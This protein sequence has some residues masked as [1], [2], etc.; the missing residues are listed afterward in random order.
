MYMANPIILSTSPVLSRTNPVIPSK[1]RDYF[2]QIIRSVPEI[3]QICPINIQH[4]SQICPKH[5]EDMS[6]N[7]EPFQTVS[8]WL[9]FG[10]SGFWQ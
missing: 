10:K 5:V 7:I 9:D 3:S 6:K 8:Q 4:I 1:N 2:G